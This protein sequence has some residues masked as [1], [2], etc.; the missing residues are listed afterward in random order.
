LLGGGEARFVNKPG[1]KLIQL[2]NLI[3]RLLWMPNKQARSFAA[4]A[5][6]TLCVAV[7]FVVRLLLGILDYNASPFASL[8][9]AILFAA[10]W[11]GVRAGIFAVLAGG[12]LAWWAFFDPRF[13][14]VPPLTFGAQLSLVIYLFASVIIVTGADYCRRLAKSL[15]DDSRCPY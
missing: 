15:K 12:V 14:F 4:Y 5:L 9:P 7:A 2:R 13:T 3:D 6:A 10:L 1:P 11:G 8:Y